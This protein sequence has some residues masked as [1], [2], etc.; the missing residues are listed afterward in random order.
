MEP[1]GTG[2][3]GWGSLLWSKNTRPREIPCRKNMYP[4]PKTK[5]NAFKKSHQHMY[6]KK[7]RS[8]HVCHLAKSDQESTE[9]A[10]SW[11]FTWKNVD[12]WIMS[13]ILFVIH[14][15]PWR[16]STPTRNQPSSQAPRRINGISSIGGG[17]WEIWFRR[18]LGS[19]R[20]IFVKEKCHAIFLGNFVGFEIFSWFHFVTNL[21][22]KLNVV[23]HN[24]P[25]VSIFF[26]PCLFLCFLSPRYKL[27]M[28]C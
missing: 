4:G 11:T 14:N 7:C 1:V 21:P 24:C 13:T 12:T 28:I 6:F 8:S 17:S 10:D 3:V 5:K 23:G 19:L 25:L 9:L 2:S 15:Q 20:K 26:A 16:E 22:R 27:G 18:S